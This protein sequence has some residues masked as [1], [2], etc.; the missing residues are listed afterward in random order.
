MNV[1]FGLFL[2]RAPWT[3]R[4]SALGAVRLGP[5][6]LTQL[7]QTRLGLTGPD[8]RH[9][10]RIRQFMAR[11]AEQDTPEAWFHGSFTVD[12]WSTAMDLLKLRDE[13]VL[14]G[15]TGIA[16]DGSTAK[17]KALASL[18]Q[19]PLPLDRAFADYPLELVHELES[20]ATS[21]WP[22]GVS[23]LELQ[24]PRDSFPAIWQRLIGALERH[25]VGVAEPAPE[26]GPV[27]EVTVLVAKTEWEAAEHTARWLASAE[28][29]RTD[30][31]AV[32][33]SASTALLD[34]ELQL[35]GL[36]RI[37]VS[38]RSRW[39]ALDQIIPLFFNVIWGPVDVQLLGEF[40]NLPISPV[41][42]G[43]ARQ[44]LRA[45][46]AQPGTGG[47]EWLRA[48]QDIGSDEDLGPGVAAELDL[49]LST[50]LLTD[51][52][53]VSG[54]AVV[55]RAQ[56]LRTQ[57]SRRVQLHP[58]LESVLSQLNEFT[59]LIDGPEPVTR[60]TIARILESVIPAS[61]NPLAGG[62]AAPW[63][64]LRSLGELCDDVDTLVWWG[65]QDDG[66]A[67]PRHWDDAERLAL[68]SV[69]VELPDP[70][71][72][73]EL[74][75]S[76]AVNAARHSRR[77]LLVRAAE[78]SGEPT[79]AH[80]VLSSLA[81][82]T[83]P[84]PLQGTLEENKKA[85]EHAI[86][87]FSV[88]PADLVHDGV[89]RLAG[90]T[91]TL[92]PV[93]PS[94]ARLLP[95]AHELGP[96]PAFMPEKLSYSQLSTLIGCSLKWVLE[97]KGRLKVADAQSVPTG[98]TMIGTLV[99]KVVEEL[100]GELYAANR[101]VPEPKEVQAKLDE[102]VPD[103]ASELLLPGNGSKLAG[104][105]PIIGNSVIKLFQTLQ[106]QGVYIRATEHAFDKPAS[107]NVNGARI[108]VQVS[109]SI[110]VLAADQQAEP[111]VI[112]LK[113]TNRSKYRREEIT[114]GDAM[115]LA[116]YHWALDDG[117]DPMSTVTEDAPMSYYLLK[118]GEFASTSTLFGPALASPASSRST[119]QRSVRA[120]EFS[121]A[122]VVGGRVLAA[123][124]QEL[125]TSD[126]Q[127]ETATADGR[128]YQKPPCNFCDFSALCGLKG[129]LS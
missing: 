16:P 113:W 10:T 103:Y 59:A 26:T 129:D 128:L 77:L 98:N 45:L 83:L 70:A 116:L 15:W 42:R 89:W 61:A 56:W 6:G 53:T 7:L 99:H 88:T 21:S 28:N 121:I 20:E 22:L 48:L 50:G 67:R 101:A 51:D 122:E 54:S 127:R 5:L 68:Q 76:V 35:R 73:A 39:R 90:R 97:K 117:P 25:G 49:L 105:R 63:V 23:R 82:S 8:A 57:L 36:P 112:D 37:G 109:G 93:Q 38:S 32:V 74:E 18:E 24:H 100:F 11:L 64:T 62:E 9:S 119:W 94:P 41:R 110:D 52:G 84:A 2:D 44:L 34:Q 19:S 17:L 66:Q 111:V 13:L 124:R 118:Q 71:A 60:K 29:P 107:F 80:P 72:L 115:Q 27:G 79:K 96:R 91:A 3:Y 125:G 4:D 86:T 69:G 108:D 43:A 31:A 55:E 123:G 120:A 30:R 106:T 65:C 78:I 102:L 40:L 58:Q 14:N 46:A 33:A 114:Q 85:V 104:L 12:P 47:E 75:L 81:F 95:A 92:T 126:E 87:A 1:L